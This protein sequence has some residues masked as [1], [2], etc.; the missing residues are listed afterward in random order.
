MLARLQIPI[1]DTG[2]KFLLLLCGKQGDLIDLLKVGFEAAF[3]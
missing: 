3:G 1:L 2:T